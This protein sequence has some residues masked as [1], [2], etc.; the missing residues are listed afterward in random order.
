VGTEKHKKPRLNVV[1]E[2]DKVTD[3]VAG[4]LYRLRK[5]GVIAY[6]NKAIGC[7]EDFSECDNESKIRVVRDVVDLVDS[8]G[9]SSAPDSDSDSDEE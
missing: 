7:E 6:K 5:Q 3:L 8:S 2:N 9:E 1:V 4:C